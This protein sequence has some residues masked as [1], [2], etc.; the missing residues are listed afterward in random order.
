MGLGATGGKYNAN[1][2]KGIGVA[3]G[4]ARL[5]G[6]A[7]V[8]LGASHQDKSTDTGFITGNS[9]EYS[10]ILTGVGNGIS[11]AGTGASMGMAFGPWG[12]AIGAIGGFLIGGISSII[13]GL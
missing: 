11:M 8:A 12:A 9:V 2:M 13:D 1:L 3:S 4:V 10:K 7:I 5:A 6:T